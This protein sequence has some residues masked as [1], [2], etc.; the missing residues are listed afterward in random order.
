[1]KYPYYEMSVP[2]FVAALKNLK[3][4]LKKGEEY[5]KTKKVPDD[6]VFGDR[7]IFDMFPFVKQ[8]QSAC[9]NAK[10][11]AARLAG[12]EAPKMEDNEKTFAELQTRVDKTLKFLEGLKPEQFEK[13]ADIKA[14][15]PYFP[16]KHI[17]GKDYLPFYAIPNFFFHL[18]TAYNILRKNGVDIGKS[19]YITG[20]IFKDN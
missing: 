18:T 12:V 2:L 15:F 7:I 4:I 8:V 5:A 6:V 20:T 17:L 16:D 10:G 11:A 19:D 3:A 1:M 9:D 14:E 13:S